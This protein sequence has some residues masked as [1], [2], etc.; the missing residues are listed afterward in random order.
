[1]SLT[2][3]EKLLIN[4]KLQIP[5]KTL[6]IKIKLQIPVKTLPINI[7]LQIPVNTLP[8]NINLQ[9]KCGGGKSN[10]SESVEANRSK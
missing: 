9:Q 7:K 2:T 5:V 4:I 1:M 6:P 3:S 8:I 10:K